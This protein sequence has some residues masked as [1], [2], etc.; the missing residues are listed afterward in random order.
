MSIQLEKTNADGT[1]EAQLTD[2]ELELAEDP[3]N[4]PVYTLLL[5]G[6]FAAVFVSQLSTGFERSIDVAAFSKPAFFDGQY[7]RILTGAA[8]HG[9]I[10][11]AGLNG[12]A[13][14]SFGRICEMLTNRAHVAIVFLLAAVGGGLMSAFLAPEGT[15]VGASG[16]IVGVIGYLAVY[17]FRRRAF[18]S[19]E[20]RKSLLINIGFILIYGLVLYRVIDNYGHIGGMITGAI[21]AFVQV[22]TDPHVDPR[23]ARSTVEFAGVTALAIYLATCGIT[24]MMLAGVA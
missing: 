19:R 20:F 7:W 23:N 15:S 12:Y 18:I 8:L 10:L 6:G 14:Y 4:T 11:H 3:D 17:A 22:P 21:Y 13:F 2:V 1:A 5:I 24:I 9:S 16:G